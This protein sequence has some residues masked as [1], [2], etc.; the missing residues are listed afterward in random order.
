MKT[1]IIKINPRKPDISKI[2]MIAEILRKSGL[3]AFPTETVYGLGAIALD[4]KAVKKIFEVKGRPTDNPLI[5]HIADKKEVHRL[6]KEVP[7]EAEKLINKF[8]PGPLTIILKKSEIV[9]DIVT[10]N[11]DSVAIRMPANKIALALIKEAKVPVAAPSA[12]LFSKPSPTS[13]EHVIQDLYG[14]IDVIIDGGKTKIGVESTIIDLTINPPM[15]L[16]P[17][18]ITLEK[19]EKVLGKVEIHQSVNKKKIKKIIAE[20]VEDRGLGL[21]IMNRLRRAER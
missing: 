17:G 7:K 6:V 2:K 16:R 5:I 8:W 14:K 10:A 12:N 15:L 11:L 18:K 9:P 4:P 1:Q 20:G 19:L 13:A 3:V 21:A